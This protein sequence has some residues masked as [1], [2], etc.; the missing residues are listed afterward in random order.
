M[1]TLRDKEVF[2]ART[3]K[4]SGRVYTMRNAHGISVSPQSRQRSAQVQKG[5]SL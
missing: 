3:V 5:A 1:K 2:V 4:V